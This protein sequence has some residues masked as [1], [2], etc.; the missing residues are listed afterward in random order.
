MAQNESN[1]F[2]AG[3]PPW[4]RLPPQSVAGFEEPVRRKGGNGVRLESEAIGT[5][6]RLGGKLFPGAEG[7]E[8]GS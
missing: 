7:G 6:M 8:G 1:A 3:T 5:G 4:T 2:V